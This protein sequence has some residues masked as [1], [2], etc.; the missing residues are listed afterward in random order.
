MKGITGYAVGACALAVIGGLCLGW[1]RLDRELARAQQTLV[2][3]DYHAADTSLQTVER[4]SPW[5]QRMPWL[6]DAAVNDLRV[7]RAGLTYWQGRF[8]ALLPN[9]QTDSVADA[10]PENVPLQVIAA[11][12][13]YRDGQPRATDRAAMLRL[14][15]ASIAAYRAVLSAARSPEAA[16]SAERAAY[17]YEYV[18]RL[19]NEILGN[20]RRTLPPPPGERVLGSRGKPEDPSFDNEFKR[21]VPLEKQERDDAEP[22]KQP[23]PV[24]KG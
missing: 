14:L 20:R 7:R 4:Y 8:S 9:D 23:P 22:G 2:T 19:R 16:R 17:N 13:T 15:D 3:A 12:A 1:S 24:R 11:D 5:I 6:G 10:A 18:V 21:Y